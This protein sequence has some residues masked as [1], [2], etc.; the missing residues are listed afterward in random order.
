MIQ[1]ICTSVGKLRQSEAGWP[2]VARLVSLMGLVHPTIELG[3]EEGHILG[4]VS[5]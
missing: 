5:G 4:R 1:G 3:Q 2:W